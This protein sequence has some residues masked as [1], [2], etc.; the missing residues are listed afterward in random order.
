M[1]QLANLLQNGSGE[2]R[3]LVDVSINARVFFGH[4]E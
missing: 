4:V 2:W 1:H 3:G